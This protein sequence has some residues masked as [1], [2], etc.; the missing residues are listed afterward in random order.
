MVKKSRPDVN[1]QGLEQMCMDNLEKIKMQ[2]VRIHTII[3]LN[4][5][6]LF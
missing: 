3:G 5:R 6:Q 2:R 1:N 4:D